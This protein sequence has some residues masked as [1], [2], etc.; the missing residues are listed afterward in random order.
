MPNPFR[1]DSP[2]SKYIDYENF[3]YYTEYC[4]VQCLLVPY[5][6]DTRKSFIA[7]PVSLSSV[8]VRGVQ[9]TGSVDAYDNETSLAI[10]LNFP[11]CRKPRVSNMSF[12]IWM[13]TTLPKI[14]VLATSPVSGSNMS[15]S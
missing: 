8:F 7:S 2:S 15:T 1:V 6:T 9:K 11:R 12:L 3:E 13:A 10:G 5:T 14:V 4:I